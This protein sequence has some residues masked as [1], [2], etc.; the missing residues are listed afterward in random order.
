MHEDFALATEGY[1]GADTKGNL[2]GLYSSSVASVIRYMSP[3]G[4]TLYEIKLPPSKFPNAN[5][6]LAMGGIV[7]DETYIYYAGT[8]ETEIL[9]IALDGTIKSRFSHRK[10]WF[11]GASKDIPSLEQGNPQVLFQAISDLFSNTTL[12][13]RIFELNAQMIMVQYTGPQGLGYQVFTKNGV[14]VAEELGVN[15]RFKTGGDGLLY[16]VVQPG[17]DDTGLP[18][19]FIEVYQFISPKN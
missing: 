19:P 7:V 5:S 18:N 10:G 8:L 11:E 2:F 15:Y 3:S 17:I 16:R 4:E 9:K 14:L 1:L 12:T 13:H 6:R